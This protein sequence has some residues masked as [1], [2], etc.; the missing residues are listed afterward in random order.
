M[1]SAEYG[2]F[3]FPSDDGEEDKMV[4]HYAKERINR[5]DVVLR[6]KMDHIWAESDVLYF[7]PFP[8]MFDYHAVAGNAAKK[9]GKRVEI[10]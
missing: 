1:T 8:L 7:P 5:P 3:M 6:R 2:R 10:I 9:A 4:E